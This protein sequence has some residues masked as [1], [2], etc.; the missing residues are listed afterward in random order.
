MNG[1]IP[2]PF[3]FSPSAENLAPAPFRMIVLAGG[4]THNDTLA[5]H[6]NQPHRCLIPLAGSPLVAHVLRTAALH[7]AIESL[8]VSV[9][10][11]AF[12]GVFDVMAQLPGRGI[13]KLVEAK[14]NL[15]DSVYAAAEGWN[16][17]LLVTTADQALLTMESIDAM[18]H[19]V[20]RPDQTDCAAFA[21]VSQE[22]IMEIDPTCDP[23]THTFSDGV[24]GNCNLYAATNLDA[25]KATE[26]FRH[27]GRFAKNPW[28][29]IRAFGLINLALMRL[30]TLTLS[31][32][33]ERISD[34]MRIAIKPVIFTDGT[35]A[36]DVNNAHTHRIVEQL[37]SERNTQGLPLQT[38]ILFR[39]GH[40]LR[41]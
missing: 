16:G 36:I 5:D 11:E 22:A 23:E 29:S 3:G 19:A 10:P 35:Q 39:N 38:Q 20:R 1:S 24:F 4:K 26:V 9:E 41:N 6:F 21:L 30:R 7:P 27:G 17:P 15:A 12:G 8:A 34:R 31:K 13:V 18:I 28:N 33:I 40:F 14:Q 37:I 2:P 25:L 32:A